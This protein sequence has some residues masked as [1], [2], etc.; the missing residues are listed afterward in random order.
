MIALG[1]I[2]LAIPK[3]GADGARRFWS[4]L[5]GNEGRKRF[6]TEDPFGNRLEILQ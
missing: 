5:I 4:G 1:P 6:F 2:Q 3:G